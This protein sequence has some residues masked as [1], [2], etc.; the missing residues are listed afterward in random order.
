MVVPTLATTESHWL[1]ERPNAS[2]GDE[3]DAK[4]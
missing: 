3:V 4:G 2:I 1:F